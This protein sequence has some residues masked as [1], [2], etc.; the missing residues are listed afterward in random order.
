MALQGDLHDFS[1]TQ[2]LNLI[3]LAGK[4]GALRLHAGREHSA[5]L[6][7]RKGKLSYAQLDENAD[8]LPL[9]LHGAQ[10]ISETQLRT[11][12]KRATG[13]PD[14]ELG[15]LLIN[16]GYVSQEDILES[17]K[18]Y[19]TQIVKDLFTWATGRFIF[20]D[21]MQLPENRIPL[22]LSLEGLIMEGARL[23][24]ELEQLELA[25]PSLDMA[26]EIRERT[27][28]NLKEVDLT[29]E[30]W[31]VVSYISPENSIRAIADTTQISE[32][33]IRRIVHGLMQAG[34][35]KL[36][37]PDGAE[38]RRESLESA[39]PGMEV[40]EQKGLVNRLMERI[41]SI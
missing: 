28:V 4:S 33:D 41:R 32:Y 10:K 3:H 6:F 5:I 26:L 16:A 15:L 40:K 30:E 9:A 25:V 24:R 17:L 35:V 12:K 14:K 23:Q 37:H 31:R 21:E 27:G 7:F 18:I 1:L 34:L 8:T 20:D 38:T 13:M 11:L 36:V 22:G 29:V 39:F 19:F 2:L